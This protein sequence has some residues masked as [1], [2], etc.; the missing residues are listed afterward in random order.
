[1]RGL[2]GREVGVG[3]GR[4]ENGGERVGLLCG[5]LNFAIVVVS[6]GEDDEG[7]GDGKKIL[8]SLR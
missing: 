3:K 5:G 8:V 1:M 6:G 2:E 7:R 4:R